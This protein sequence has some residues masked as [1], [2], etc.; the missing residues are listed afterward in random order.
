[1]FRPTSRT[2]CLRTKRLRPLVE[3][4]Y[5]TSSIS[6]SLTLR[7]GINPKD[8]PRKLARGFVAGSGKRMGEVKEFLLADIG[9]G[10]AEVEVCILADSGGL[11]S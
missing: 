8:G 4:T 10:I 11:I 6:R 1:M 3:R 5:L 9:E 2:L 7:S